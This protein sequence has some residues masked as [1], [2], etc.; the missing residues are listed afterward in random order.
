MTPTDFEAVAD[1]H[2]L[3]P[4]LTGCVFDIQR[5][6]IH[7][8]P[9]IRTTVFLKGCPLRCLWC[10]NPESISP[11]PLL[12]F[13]A[14]KCISCGDCVD[15]CT[16]QA[17]ILDGDQNHVFLREKCDTCGECAKVCPSGALEIVGR[18]LSYKEVLDTVLRDRPFYEASGGGVTLSGGE[19][20]RQIDF[21]EALLSEVKQAGIHTAVE[22]AGHVTF[23]RLARM[24]PHTDLFLFDVK[25]TND[26]LHQKF[27]GVPNTRILDN[28]KSLH[29]AGASVIVRLPVIP[30]LNDREEHFEAVA[31]I[32]EPLSGLTGVEVMPYHSLGTAKLP[33]LGMDSTDRVD[34]EPPTKETIADWVSS[35]RNLGVNVIN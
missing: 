16:N 18:D 17:H 9:G 23:N 15:V 10:H 28:L 24:L 13:L 12:S 7:D 26:A 19:P 30:G 32:V 3:T 34:P 25:E 14:D 8:G 33:R 11:E 29:D 31:R 4:V 35:L 20:L 27:T 1:S 2:S 21:A 5:F 6:S 22:T